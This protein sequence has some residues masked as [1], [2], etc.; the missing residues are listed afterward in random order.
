MTNDK[1]LVIDDN[2]T[3]CDYLCNILDAK[4]FCTKK[5]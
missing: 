2:K 1:I 5:A 3:F 4:G